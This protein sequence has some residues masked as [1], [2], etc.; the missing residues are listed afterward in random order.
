MTDQIL[1]EIRAEL[2]NGHIKKRHPFRYFTFA[3]SHN[4]SPR[5]RTVVLRKMLPDLN[6]LFYTDARSHKVEDF[7]KNSQVSALF[8]HPKKL[9]QVRVEGEAQIITDPKQL[10]QYWN[11]IQES[12]KKDYIT[13]R[14]PGSPI[15]NPDNVDYLEEEHHFCAVKIVPKCIEYLRLKRPNHIRVLFIKKEDKWNGKFLVP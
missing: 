2:T 15:K 5:Q 13:E 3:T 12:S 9:M 4:G 10:K 1:K 14:A 6:I 7:K 11:N 8:Y